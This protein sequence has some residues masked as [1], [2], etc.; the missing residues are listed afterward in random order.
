MH[1][2]EKNKRWFVAYTLPRTEKKVHSILNNMGVESFLPLQKEVRVWK[3]R[4]KKLEVPMFPNYIFVH[5][6]PGDRY[7]ILKI[8]EVVR[9]ISFEGKPATVSSELIEALRRVIDSQPEVTGDPIYISGM[10]VR[11]EDGPFAG[12]EGLMIRKNGRSR[13][14]IEIQVLQRNVSIDISSHIVVP[15]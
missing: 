14:V 7:G 3:D 15:I 10:A 2:P 8:R 6:V 12:I 11:V 4:R 5:S 9:Y 1:S 13:L